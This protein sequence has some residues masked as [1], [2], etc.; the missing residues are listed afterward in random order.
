M[1]S[2][3]FVA[4]CI[5]LVF[6]GSHLAKHQEPT[7]R[8]LVSRQ[9]RRIV[10]MAPSVTETLFALGL[11]DRVVGVTRYCNYPAEA[12]AKPRIGGLIDPNVEAVVALRPDLIVLLEGSQQNLPAFDKLGLPVLVVDH[13]SIEGILASMVQIGGACGAM[14]RAEA[15]VVELRARIGRVEERVAGRPRPRVMLAVDRTLGAGRIEDVYIAGA[16]G[17]LGRIIA[18]AGGQNAYRGT[19][20]FPVISREGILRMN[21]QVIVDVLPRLAPGADRQ[22]TRA[23]WKDLAQVEAVRSGRVF[24]LDEDYVSVPGPRFVLLVEKLARLIHPEVEWERE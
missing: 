17:H 24:V 4:A 10:S 3:F 22:K 18:M 13:R 21:P 20:P 12:A 15:L 14:A 1:S 19:V 11:G 16:D 8:R 2:R 7:A 23:D 9:A 5:V 6:V